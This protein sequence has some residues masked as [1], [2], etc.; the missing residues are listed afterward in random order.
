MHPT[1][2]RPFVS[3]IQSLTLL[4]I[5]PTPSNLDNGNEKNFISASVSERARHLFVL[6]HL[7]GPK[8]ATGAEWANSLDALIDSMQDTLDKVFRS[9]IEDRIPSTGKYDFAI[10]NL[11]EDVVSDQKPTPLALP[12]WT[13]IHAGIE[14]LDGLLHTLQA[15]LASATATVVTVPVGSILNLVDRV[16]STFPPGNGRNPRVKPEIGRDEREGL[17]VGLP[18]LQIAAIGVCSLMVSRMGHSSAAIISTVLEQLLWTFESQHGN[19]GFRRAAYVLVSQILTTFG[20]SLPRTYAI[21]L[22]RCVR[23]CCEDVLPSAESQL[24][25]GQASFPDTRKNPNG[26]ISTNADSYLRSATNQVDLSGASIGI[27]QVARELLSLTL[28]NLPNEYFPFSLR[29]N[30]DRTAIFTNNEKAMLASAM[31]PI[32]KRKGQK[33]TSSILPFLARAY[34]E[35]LGVETLLRPQMPP[36]QSRRSD[37]RDMELDEEEDKYMQDHP[38]ISNSDGLYDESIITSLNGNVEEN[39]VAVGHSDAQLDATPGAVDDGAPS[40][41]SKSA[42]SLNSTKRDRDEESDFDTRKFVEGDSTERVEIGLAS[43]RPRM[44]FAERLGETPLAPADPATVSPGGPG[45]ALDKVSASDSMTVSG[46]QPISQQEYSDESDFEMPVLNMDPD[47][48]EEEEEED[49]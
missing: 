25:G 39:F 15:F 5:A 4:L 10:S 33:Q 24:Q 8:N 35:G 2:F 30:I 9:L 19:D 38:Q 45:Q 7:S 40:T 48:D 46:R 36:I 21:S 20:P 26:I 43:K 23:M 16:L 14:R 13:G 18:R 17:W 28:T 34:P 41:E 6:L 11:V 29:C 22:S 49:D 3:Q 47:T 42:P 27:I 31:N 37:G 32:L 44:E 1:S 12:A